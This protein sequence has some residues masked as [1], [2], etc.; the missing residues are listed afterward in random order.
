MGCIGLRDTSRSERERIHQYGITAYTMSDVIRHGI[1]AVCDQAISS[2]QQHIDGIAV[3][4]DMDVCDPAE[5]PGV[6][7][8]VRGGFRLSEARVVMESIAAIESLLVLDLV[9]VNPM[10]DPTATTLQAALT[11]LEAAVGL[12]I[13]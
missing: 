13:V 12:T 3:S 5:A 11:L 2:L 4:F 9:E 1:A 7:A 10:L 8:T 6:Q